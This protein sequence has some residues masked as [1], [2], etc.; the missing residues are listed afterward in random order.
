MPEFT[1]AALDRTGRKLTGTLSARSRQDALRQLDG[2]RLQPIAVEQAGGVPA[3]AAAKAAAGGVVKLSRGEVVLFTEELAA[4]LEA[5]LQ[6][7]PALQIMERRQAGARIRGVAGRLRT[8]V[9]DGAS[10]SGSLRHASPSFSPLYG[11]MVAA[12]EASG[13]LTEILQKLAGYLRSVHQLQSKATEALVY[14]SFLLGA[15]LLLVAL[16]M[17]VLL[18]QLRSLLETSGRGLP[19]TTQVLVS[20]GEFV[21]GFWWLIG[22]GVLL[23]GYGFYRVVQTPGGRAWWDR[24]KLRLPLVGPLL[25][26]NFVA[27]FSHTL[28][29]LT[30]NGVPLV[31]ALELM[32][33]IARNTTL[34][35]ALRRVTQEVSEGG[36]LSKSLQRTGEFPGLFLDM[37]GVGEQTGDLPAALHRV[38]LRYE[39]EV[40]ARI[41]GMIGLIQ[42]AIIVALA[43]F[44]LLIS[45]SLFSGIA[46]TVQS[47][48][49]QR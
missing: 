43:V 35:G 25:V 34:Q 31:Q 11:A 41:K 38:A 46:E 29:T 49:V 16:F 24:S 6:L 14:P 2:Q 9:R 47:L 1:Y 45:V 5:G 4:L 15:G 19:W 42:P 10:L 13:A 40:E 30:Q 26:A 21:G 17:T 32:Q 22:A 20:A 28:A 33:N 36:A 8:M 48:R 7:E 23:G 18:P 12:G 27:Q 37:V 3:R 44:V 39:G